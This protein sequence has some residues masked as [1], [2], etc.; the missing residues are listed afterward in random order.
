[1]LDSVDLVHEMNGGRQA[2]W[3]AWESPQIPKATAF[4]CHL[5]SAL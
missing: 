2:D 1:M 4:H 5:I 3:M